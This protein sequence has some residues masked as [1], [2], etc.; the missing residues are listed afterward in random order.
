MANS[1]RTNV[2]TASEEAPVHDIFGQ[3]RQRVQERRQSFQSEPIT[4][5]ATYQFEKDLKAEFDRAGREILEAELNQVEPTDKQQAAPKVRYHKATYRINKGSSRF[6][7]VNHA[8][9]LN[10]LSV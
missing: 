6:S 8:A 1:T 3:M 2:A 9:F 7:I 5:A 4:P 10:N